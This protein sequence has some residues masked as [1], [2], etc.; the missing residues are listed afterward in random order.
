MI[1]EERYKCEVDGVSI[2]HGLGEGEKV[3]VEKENPLSIMGL[4]V[5]NPVVAF[6]QRRKPQV[7]RKET[8]SANNNSSR[9][10][11]IDLP[12]LIVTRLGKK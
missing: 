5:G 10:A 9:S 8:G 7:A 1:R 2:L 12:P 11:I 3:R 6:R 4:H